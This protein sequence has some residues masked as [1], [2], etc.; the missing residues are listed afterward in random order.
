MEQIEIIIRC[1]D[2]KI[3]HIYYRYNWF[4]D[5]G[6][7]WYTVPGVSNMMF[8]CGGIQFTAA[9]FNGWYLST[10][11]GCRDLCDTHRY[12]MLEVRIFLHSFFKI[13]SATH[14]IINK[15]SRAV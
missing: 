7:K 9:P 2:T 11:I 6:M 3:F 15:N 12:N 10:E 8:D 5:L 14:F 13:L 1:T 4:E